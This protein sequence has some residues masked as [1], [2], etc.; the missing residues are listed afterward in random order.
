M[1]AEDPDGLRRPFAALNLAEVARANR[2]KIYL[3]DARRDAMLRAA[4]SYMS[5]I[6]DYRGFDPQLGYRH[7]VAHASDLLM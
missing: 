7:G 4:T 5:A 1:A 3:T 6:E 2:I